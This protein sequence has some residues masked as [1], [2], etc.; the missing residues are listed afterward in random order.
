[1]FQWNPQL[2]FFGKSS[3]TI[4]ASLGTFLEDDSSDV[5]VRDAKEFIFSFFFQILTKEGPLKQRDVED[6]WKD[7]DVN[8]VLPSVKSICD[9]L[10]E[11]TRFCRIEDYICLSDQIED[12]YNTVK[13]EVAETFIMMN[14]DNPLKSASTP[15]T[16]SQLSSSLPDLISDNTQSE[17]VVNDHRICPYGLC[18][19][20]SVVMKSG[21]PPN[22]ETGNKP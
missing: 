15:Q 4:K 2:S 12:L 8:I 11:S 18:E 17:Q 5:S 19:C 10:L 14:F 9:I 7:S 3:E 21:F 6:L 22:C 1:M 13:T 20:Y 16:S